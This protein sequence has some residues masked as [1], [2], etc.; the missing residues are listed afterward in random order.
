[1]LCGLVESEGKVARGDCALR[2]AYARHVDQDHQ[3]VGV[4]HIP[5]GAL[6]R[7]GRWRLPQKRIPRAQAGRFAKVF[8]PAAF[9]ALAAILHAHLDGGIEGCTVDAGLAARDDLH[10][11]IVIPARFGIQ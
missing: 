2:Y 5:F 3:P 8:C 10:T 6:Y 7:R 9:R 11:G 4:A 1:M